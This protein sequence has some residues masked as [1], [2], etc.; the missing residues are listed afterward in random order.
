MLQKEG[1]FNISVTYKIKT[2]SETICTFQILLELQSCNKALK[3]VLGCRAFGVF[4]VYQENLQARLLNHRIQETG[5]GIS[6]KRSRWFVGF[7]VLVFW[8]WVFFMYNS[9][10]V[11]GVA[12]NDM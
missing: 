3:C 1:I 9:S 12:L 4:Y 11:P 2:F 7:F 10:I 6:H 5:N 8:L